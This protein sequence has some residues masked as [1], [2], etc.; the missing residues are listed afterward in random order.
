MAALSEEDGLTAVG[1]I[2][3]V[4]ARQVRTSVDYSETE[5]VR[6]VWPES[7]SADALQIGVLVVFAIMGVYDMDPDLIESAA[8]GIMPLV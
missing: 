7:L 6:A 2:L 1:V 3:G 5:M 8:G 4:A